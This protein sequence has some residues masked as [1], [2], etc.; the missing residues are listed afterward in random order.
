MTVGIDDRRAAQASL[1]RDYLPALRAS[2]GPDIAFTDA[3]EAHRI[4]ASYTVV[5]TFLGYTASYRRSDGRGLGTSLV[6]R[7]NAAL[8]DLDVVA[9]V[10]AAL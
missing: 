4:Q 5:A 10:R 6:E 2:G 1:I 9:A 3:W 8:D 7:A